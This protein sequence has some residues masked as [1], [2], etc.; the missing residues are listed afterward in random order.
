[1][2]LLIS[3]VLP[4]CIVNFR[5]VFIFTV[6]ID[7]EFT[8]RRHYFCIL[9]VRVFY[10]T[11]FFLFSCLLIVLICYVFIYFRN[12]R[13]INIYITSKKANLGCIFLYKNNP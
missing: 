6:Y 10:Y 11:Y 13:N 4:I 9:I 2:Q 3:N 7:S 8:I 12:I 1:M 5:N